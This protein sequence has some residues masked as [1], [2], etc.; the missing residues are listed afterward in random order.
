MCSISGRDWWHD[1]VSQRQR[2]HCKK[3]L[4]NK[5][6]IKF[7]RTDN[8]YLSNMNHSDKYGPTEGNLFDI[9][10]S[11]SFVL[12]ARTQHTTIDENES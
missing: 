6:F 10:C 9:V 11:V 1:W 3:L 2:D 4:Y 7:P 5:T 8:G 12:C